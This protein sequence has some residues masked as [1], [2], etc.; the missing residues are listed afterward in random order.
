[1]RVLHG[2]NSLFSL[3]FY[4]SSMKLAIIVDRNKQGLERVEFRREEVVQKSRFPWWLNGKE[5]TCQ[6][7]RLKRCG[8]IPWRRKWQ[9]TPV[10]LPLKFHG[11]RSLAGYSP[12]D[13]R[14]GHDRNN[15][16]RTLENQSYNTCSTA[17]NRASGLLSKQGQT[18]SR[19]QKRGEG[20]SQLGAR[21]D[22]QANRAAGLC[23]QGLKS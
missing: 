18:K 17:K 16:A 19:P 8:F 23:S 5:S 1:M 11:Q 4:N 15:L 2:L 7:R 13:C 3:M 21:P 22:H 9:P 6:C 10:F 14:V 20:L 12:Q